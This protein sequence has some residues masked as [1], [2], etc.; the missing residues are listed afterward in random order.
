M[1]NVQE[2]DKNEDDSIVPAPNCSSIVQEAQ[3]FCV[4]VHFPSKLQE[5]E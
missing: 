4:Q 1:K 3:V 2:A 5:R